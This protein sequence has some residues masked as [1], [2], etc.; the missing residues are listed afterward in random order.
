[1][2]RRNTGTTC[3]S[4]GV[5]EDYWRRPGIYAEGFY[6]HSADGAR[7]AMENYVCLSRV[8]KVAAARASPATASSPGT[9]D[10]RTPLLPIILSGE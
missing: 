5:F 2:P 6:D 3:S 1:M 9:L 4:S 10:P 8:K 7:T